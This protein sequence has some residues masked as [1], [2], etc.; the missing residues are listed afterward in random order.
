MHQPLLPDIPKPNAD[1][2]SP[3]S[4]REAAQRT[5]M[6]LPFLRHERRHGR[7]PAHLRLGRAVRYRPIAIDA[8]LDERTITAE[9]GPT[10]AFESK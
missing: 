2:A 8:W 10:E 3:I 9:S 5:G 4:E 7:G 6:S 1:S